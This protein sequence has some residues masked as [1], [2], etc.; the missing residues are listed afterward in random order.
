MA[1]QETIG[2]QA[3]AA[4]KLHGQD[5]GHQA[6]PSLGVVIEAKTALVGIG[7]APPAQV[8]EIADD[9]AAA[10]DAQKVRHPLVKAGRDQAAVEIPEGGIGKRAGLAALAPRTGMQRLEPVQPLKRLRGVARPVQDQWRMGFVVAHGPANLLAAVSRHGG[11]QIVFG[12]NLQGGEGGG[13]RWA[14]QTCRQPQAMAQ[15]APVAGDARQGQIPFPT[16]LVCLHGG[17]QGPGGF[18]FPAGQRQQ[19][20]IFRHDPVACRITGFIEMQ[21]GRP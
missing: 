5:M 3:F 7:H 11:Q 16:A 10:L 4:I 6:R 8:I 18:A 2:G 1:G 13:L 12:P 19:P 17:Q 14:Q 21:G 9:L 15:R 20:V